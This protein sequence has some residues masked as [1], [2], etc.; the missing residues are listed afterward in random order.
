MSYDEEID[1]RMRKDYWN[2]VLISK[3]Y[4][5]EEQSRASTNISN[6]YNCLVER[7]KE[8]FKSNIYGSQTT[9]SLDLKDILHRQKY[10]CPVCFKGF[11]QKSN[12]TKHLKQV[13]EKRKP[14]ACPDINCNKMFSQNSVKLTHY[15]TVHCGEKPYNCPT[16][17]KSFSDKSNMKKHIRNIHLKEKPFNCIECGSRFGEKRSLNDHINCVHLKRRPFECPEMSCGRTF[18]QKT[19]MIKHYKTQHNKSS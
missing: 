10:V 11:N 16:C 5:E 13:H 8:G 2:T 15:R 4:S 12:R 17:W 18:G 1:N 6:E 3:K 14:F 7:R 19:H 9:S